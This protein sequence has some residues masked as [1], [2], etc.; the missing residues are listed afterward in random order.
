MTQLLTQNYEKVRTTITLPVYLL[1]RSQR[2]VNAG[3]VPSRTALIELALNR[4]LD[5]LERQEIDHQF[6]A[7]ADDKA[8][9]TLNESIAEEFSES[10]WEALMLD[11][12]QEVA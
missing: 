9:H 10:D 7:M 8:Y 12:K 4:F 11:E 3:T 6:E 2:F 1:D 5:E